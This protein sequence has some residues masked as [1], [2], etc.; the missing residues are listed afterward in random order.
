VTPGTY[1]P[2]E[3]VSP[4]PLSLAI[5]NVENLDR[6]IRG[7]RRE[8]FSVVIQLSIMLS[9]KASVSTCAKEKRVR[10][11]IIS[12]WAVSMGIGSEVVVEAWAFQRVKSEQIW[13]EKRRGAHHLEMLGR[14]SDG[15]DA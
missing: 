8:S 3:G 11:T 14:V 9:S 6:P 4:R 2:F 10:Q 1:A 15:G 7:T 5:N 13:I 12:S